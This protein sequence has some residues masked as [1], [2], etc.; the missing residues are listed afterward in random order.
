MAS[1]RGNAGLTVI[2]K[3][4]DFVKRGIECGS[5]FLQPADVGTDV[6]V[7]AGILNQPYTLSFE[8]TFVRAGSR[9]IPYSDVIELRVF[10][11]DKFQGSYYRGRWWTVEIG[12]ESVDIKLTF[13][14]KLNTPEH[15]AYKEIYALVQKHIVP[16]LVSRVVAMSL[17]PGADFQFGPLRL[18]NE[19]IT[20]RLFWMLP[21]SDSIPWSEFQS[22]QWDRGRFILYRR[23]TDNGLIPWWIGPHDMRMNVAMADV[24]KACYLVRAAPVPVAAQTNSGEEAVPSET[25]PK[26][27]PAKLEGRFAYSHDDGVDFTIYLIAFCMA[28][29]GS[30]LIGALGVPLYLWEL[31]HIHIPKLK[32]IVILTILSAMGLL[33][34]LLVYWLL[35]AS[36]N[37]SFLLAMLMAGICAPLLFLSHVYFIKM[38]FVQVMGESDADLPEFIADNQVDPDLWMYCALGFGYFGYL[39]FL[40]AWRE[41]QLAWCAHCKAWMKRDVW[42]VPSGSSRAFILAFSS[43]DPSLIR[44]ENYCR[45]LYQPNTMI[46]V[47]YSPVFRGEPNRIYVSISECLTHSIYA[48]PDPNKSAWYRMRLTR[49]EVERVMPMVKFVSNE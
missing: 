1:W 31:T 48:V 37:R 15:E 36:K 30:V 45:A 20:K 2:G 9:V 38:Y 14:A 41:S 49:E 26:P 25:A 23:D 17:K 24:L 16:S 18:S 34:G 39:V 13:N 12:S 35:W 6:V 40:L 11:T 47:E 21:L 10:G 3:G 43:G 4:N 42:R 28:I 27:V 44:K 5:S 33:C 19:G 46:T 8:E 22:T 29:I 7:N 32:V